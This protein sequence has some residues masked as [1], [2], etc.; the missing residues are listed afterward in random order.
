MDNFPFP[1]GVREH[2]LEK[3]RQQIMFQPTSTLIHFEMA[4]YVEMSLL[5]QLIDNIIP[6][7]DSIGMNEQELH[8]LEQVLRM[9]LIS[10]STDSNPRVATTLIQMRNIF[11]MINKN[12]RK[13]KTNPFRRMLTRIH[14]HTLA[15]QAFLV[16]KDD[17]KWKNT[18]NA[19]AKSS[20]TAHRHVC[21]TEHVNPES[22][23]IV[24][25]NSFSTASEDNSA[26]KRI[27]FDDSNPVSCW[28]EIIK[29]DDIS[30][31]INIQ[32]CISPVL[33]CRVAKQTAGAGDNV[34]ASGLI[35][36]I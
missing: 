30:E 36:Q 16:V 21:G 27:V 6:Y 7:S 18:K 3:I 26:P 17:I 33:V 19:A 34:S 25:D 12:A 28:D 35:L 11:K 29:L 1:P 2:R 8:N 4:S 9:G 22:A 32:I 23:Y 10:F 5:Q 13:D 20:L 24:L 15:Y 31:G 14:V